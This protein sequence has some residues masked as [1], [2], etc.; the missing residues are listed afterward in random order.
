[1]KK[2]GILIIGIIALMLS[3]SCEV[4]KPVRYFEINGERHDLY[5]GFMDDWGTNTSGIINTRYYAVSFR[6][7][8]DFPRDYMTFFIG[9]LDTK[10]LEVGTYEYHFP[11]DRGE[12][13]DI[14]VGA[15][16]KYDNDGWEIGGIVF[17]ENEL[18]FDGVIRISITDKGRYDFFFDINMTVREEYKDDYPEAV[19][20]LFGEYNDRL[21][22]DT[23]VV[24]L[25]WY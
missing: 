24:N 19:Y 12:F 23:D 8:D 11:A 21:I 20:N 15:G 4:E 13:S 10:Q 16:I 7:S 3:Q 25:E 9:S 18:D 14:R 17:D 22:L 2:L 6:S 5:V 1:M